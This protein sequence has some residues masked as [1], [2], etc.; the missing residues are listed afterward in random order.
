[1][2]R[3]TITTKCSSKCS[4]IE[5]YVLP[6]TCNDGNDFKK[7]M[8]VRFDQFIKLIIQSNLTPVKKPEDKE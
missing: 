7:G 3:V 1:M 6:T 4:G 8:L 5:A 2:L